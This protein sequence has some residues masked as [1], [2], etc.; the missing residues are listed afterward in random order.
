MTGLVEFWF[1]FVDLIYIE[2]E[3]VWVPVIHMVDLFGILVSAECISLG[4]CGRVQN[5]F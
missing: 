2:M 5:R 4:C 1:A 3:N